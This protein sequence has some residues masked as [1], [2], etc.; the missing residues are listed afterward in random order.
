M[1]DFLFSIKQ[2]FKGIIMK[3]K[4]SLTLILLIL[5]TVITSIISGFYNK[6]GI[7]YIAILGLSAL[8]FLA[9]SFQ[10]MELKK[11][12]SFHQGNQLSCALLPKH[13]KATVI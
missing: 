13:R 1:I 6:L 4:D 8:K 3:K 5:L 9:V 7:I 2:I 10:F 12:N 11:A